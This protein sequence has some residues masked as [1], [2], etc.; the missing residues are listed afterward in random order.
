MLKNDLLLKSAAN[1]LITSDMG[2]LDRIEISLAK[3]RVLVTLWVLRVDG[4][5]GFICHQ[6]PGPGNGLGLADYTGGSVCLQIAS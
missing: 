6:N 2:C 3:K 4:I 1:I 5:F